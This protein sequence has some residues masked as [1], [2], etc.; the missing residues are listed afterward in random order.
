MKFEDAEYD[1]NMTSVCL[2]ERIWWIVEWIYRE[3]ESE[4]DIII[5]L[6]G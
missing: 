3:K 1:E 5:E 2:L 6:G 4:G